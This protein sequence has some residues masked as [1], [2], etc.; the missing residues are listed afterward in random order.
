MRVWLLCVIF[1]H[2]HIAINYPIIGIINFFFFKFSNYDLI[3]KFKS[4]V[5]CGQDALLILCNAFKTIDGVLFLV[6]IIIIM[7]AWIR[8]IT[9][10]TTTINH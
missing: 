1:V 2:S 5:Q 9:Y 10:I 3:L 4:A 6:I 8:N 7:Q